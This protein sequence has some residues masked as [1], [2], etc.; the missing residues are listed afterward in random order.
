MMSFEKC[1]SLSNKHHDQ[2][3]EDFNI[4]NDSLVRPAQPRAELPSKLSLE[5]P[6]I[7]RLLLEFFFL[8]PI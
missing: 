2:D 1:M 4:S 5:Y 8:E 7:G 3:R 6:V